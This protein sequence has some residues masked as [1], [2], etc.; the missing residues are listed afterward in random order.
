MRIKL[1]NERMLHFLIL[2]LLIAELSYVYYYQT[3]K[4]GNAESHLALGVAYLNGSERFTKDT[5]KGIKLLYLSA[6]QGNA[7]AQAFIS[8]AYKDGNGLPQ[9]SLHAYVWANIA[10]SNG[11]RLGG[12]QK[13]VLVLKMS[14][15]QIQEA[16]RLSVKCVKQGYKGC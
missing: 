5:D 7:M 3:T 12:L 4:Q 16:Q 15:S 8:E 6:E 11:S 2:A 14:R 10:E 1:L 9:S 13:K